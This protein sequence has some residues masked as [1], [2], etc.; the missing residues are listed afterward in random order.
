MKKLKG[1]TIKLE[2]LN[3]SRSVRPKSEYWIERWH[4]LGLTLVA[5]SR[6]ADRANETVRFC[7]VIISFT[8]FGVIATWDSF[9]DSLLLSLCCVVLYCIVL[10]LYASINKQNNASF[11]TF[12]TFPF[13]STNNVSVFSIPFPDSVLHYDLV[14][15]NAY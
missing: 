8:V 7:R 1:W 9:I 15:I 4:W 14:I 5:G 13:L 11:A 6:R 3:W 10:Y 12:L 2:Q